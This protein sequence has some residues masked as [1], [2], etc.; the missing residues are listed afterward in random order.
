MNAQIE[1][2]VM[3]I[4]TIEWAN[5]D[6]RLTGKKAVKRNLSVLHE[7]YFFSFAACRVTRCFRWGHFDESVCSCLHVGINISYVNI[8]VRSSALVTLWQR[9]L[10]IYHQ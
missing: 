6:K 5:E 4:V 8:L 2:A 1:P 10:R 3:F 7:S 9:D